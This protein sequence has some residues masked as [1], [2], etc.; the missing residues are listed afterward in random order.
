[1]ENLFRPAF[2]DQ[3]M[4]TSLKHPIAVSIFFVLVVTALINAA[5]QGFLEGQ[6]KI[7]SRKPVEL[8]DENTAPMTVRNYADYPLIILTRDETKQIARIIADPDGNYRA[9]LPPG[10]YI[11]DV[12]GRVPKQL[13]VRPQ[14]FTVIS[15]ATVHVDM[16]IVTGSSAEASAPQE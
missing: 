15:D 1:M 4:S 2:F 10:A 9:A 14:P 11:L 7:I 8:A 16:T 13:R 3:I 12:E 6:L 5:P